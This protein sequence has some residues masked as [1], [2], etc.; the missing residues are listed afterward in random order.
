MRCNDY[1]R[2]DQFNIRNDLRLFGILNFGHWN[3]L[4][5]VFCDLEFNNGTSLSLLLEIILCKL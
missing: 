1:D 5:F 3:C 4:L 2:F